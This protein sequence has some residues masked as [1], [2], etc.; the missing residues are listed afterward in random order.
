M[1]SDDYLSEDAAD[2]LRAAADDL[3]DA[4]TSLNRAEA[5]EARR[6][7]LALDLTNMRQHARIVSNVPFYERDSN[8]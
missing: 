8:D 4:L 1:M 6:R 7:E 3:S 2:H 5:A